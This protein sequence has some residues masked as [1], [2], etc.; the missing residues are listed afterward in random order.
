M[1]NPLFSERPTF[2]A[3]Q[4]CPPHLRQ[5]IKDTVKSFDDEWLL[6]SAEGELFDS[7]KACLT[8][9]QAFAFSQGFAVVTTVLKTER[10]CFACI[11]HSDDT[12]NWCKLE[13]H[14]KKDFKSSKIVSK[15]QKKDTFKQTC[16]CHWEMYW[17]IRLIRKKDSKQVAEQLN[18]IRATHN[19]I[20]ALNP[21]I[22]KIHQKIT[23]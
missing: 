14:V 15:R 1:S 6:P 16:S 9:L 23:S 12:K 20:L 22:Y 10:F 8:R 11:Y 17:S 7:K 4:L 19:Y 2:V 18:I 21:F 3:H 13:Q 5:L